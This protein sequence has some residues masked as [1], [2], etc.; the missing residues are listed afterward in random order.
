MLLSLAFYLVI[1]LE[2]Q[3]SSHVE[4]VLCVDSWDLES[5]SQIDFGLVR[6]TGDLEECIETGWQQLN[7]PQKIMDWLAFN[8]FDVAPII[9]RPKGILKAATGYG[10]ES[11]VING[12]IPKVRIPIRINFVD[13]F[14]VHN[15]TVALVATDFG[16]LLG[17]QA[18][19]NRK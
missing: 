14:F 6:T 18:I 2:A 9:N 3:S 16:D 8:G 15:L 12:S 5:K 4:V 13:R 10:G 17:V 11:F 7:D 1:A 19:L